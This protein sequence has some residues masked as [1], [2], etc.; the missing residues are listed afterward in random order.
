MK[1]P[2]LFFVKC[3]ILGMSLNLSMTGQA[4][5]LDL[6]SL[7]GLWA[8]PCANGVLKTEFFSGQRVLL[9]EMFFA[10][11]EC[12]RPIVVFINEGTYQLPAPGW[13]DFKFTSV[14]LRLLTE[15][16]VND[17][18]SRKVCGFGD[19]KNSEEKEISGRPCEIFVIGS[20][21]RIPT[22]G[23]MRYGI[24]RLDLS[25]NRLSFGKLSKDKNASTPEKRPHDLDPQYYLKVPRLRP[26]SDSVLKR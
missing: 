7:Q 15:G 2:A 6:A 3:L 20:P 22:V 13:I 25:L 21:Q 17:F 18:N 10:D 11:K 12:R 1:K 23:D 14:R 4:Q 19:W 9:N 16:A 26:P 8:Q 5:T 24:Y